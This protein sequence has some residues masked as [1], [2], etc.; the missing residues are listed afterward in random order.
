MINEKNKKKLFI[1]TLKDI[2]NNIFNSTKSFI[3]NQLKIFSDTYRCSCEF[4][5]A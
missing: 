4:N 2:S 3:D 5:L 1:D